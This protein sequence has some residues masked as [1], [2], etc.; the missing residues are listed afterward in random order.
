[1][2]DMKNQTIELVRGLLVKTDGYSDESPGFDSDS[3][4]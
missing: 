1:M 3:R 4:R 2:L